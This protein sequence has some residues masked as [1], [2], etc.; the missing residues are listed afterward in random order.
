MQASEFDPTLLLKP[1]GL[2]V[3]PVTAAQVPVVPT[4]TSVA[5]IR[6]AQGGPAPVMPVRSGLGLQRAG[7]ATANE[8]RA[9][10]D[11]ATAQGAQAMQQ[12]ADVAAAEAAALDPVI[13]EKQRQ[14][15]QHAVRTQ[16]LQEQVT[17][18][19]NRLMGDY[20]GTL[21]ELKQIQAEKQPDVWGKD[22]TRVSAMV[23]AILGGIGAGM[24]GGQNQFFAQLDNAIQQKISDQKR[25]ADLVGNRAQG[26]LNQYQLLRQKYGDDQ[27]AEA[28]LYKNYLDSLGVMVDRI[29]NKFA[30][31]KAQAAANGL[32][33]QLAQEHAKLD[34]GIRSRFTQ[35]AAQGLAM[36]QEQ[37]MRRRELEAK[38]A[39]PSGS[40]RVIPGLIGEATSDKAL[41]EAQTIETAYRSLM[42]MLDEME[43]QAKKGRTLPGTE[44][45]RRGK[46]LA[47]ALSL[48][49]KNAAELGALTGPDLELL[50]KML[51]SDPGRW[52]GNVQPQI[53]AARRYIK[54]RTSKALNVRG[55]IGREAQP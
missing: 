47:T 38:L 1:S 46:A 44:E 24:T 54:N 48:E 6:A 30:S 51:P 7:A 36:S 28:G 33:A 53:E 39:A 5:E 23:G 11:I 10:Q 22:E 42:P 2:V 15:D 31:P 20:K 35:T 26:V 40:G 50:E 21:D 55:F 8:A 19:S 9:M 34:E 52:A 17:N 45:D 32:K 12:Q 43:T 18:E 25:R 4:P 14:V 41:T 16:A 29:A 3:D 49:M 27:L 13:A 37:A